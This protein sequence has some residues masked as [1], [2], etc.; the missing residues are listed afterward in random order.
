MMHKQTVEQETLDHHKLKVIELIDRIAEFVGEP[1]QTKECSDKEKNTGDADEIAMKGQVIDRQL[2][3]LDGS[4]MAI[5]GS[6][7]SKSA[8]V[9]ALNNYLENIKSLEGKLEVHCT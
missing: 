2:S 3:L 8:D 1:S 7:E 5:K 9:H 4:V 6:V